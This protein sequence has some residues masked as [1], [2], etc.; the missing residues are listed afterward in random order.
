MERGPAVGEAGDTNNEMWSLG[1]GVAE[2]GDE[3]FGE[4]LAD[5]TTLSLVVWRDGCWEGVDA[6]CPVDRLCEVWE[7]VHLV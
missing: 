6:V 5:D 2:I 4:H 1:S 3:D 7:G